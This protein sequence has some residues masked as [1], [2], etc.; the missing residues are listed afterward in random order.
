MDDQKSNSIFNELME[1]YSYYDDLH[2]R[3]LHMKPGE[4]KNLAEFLIKTVADYGI[5]IQP[6]YHMISVA[7]DLNIT[8]IKEFW[9]LFEIIYSNFKIKPEVFNVEPLTYALFCKKIDIKANMFHIPSFLEDDYEITS[10]DEII[11]AY[12]SNTV[13][14]YIIHDDIKS[15]IEYINNSQGFD[16]NSNL[17]EKSLIE[18]CC[19]YGASKCFKFLRSNEIDGN[20]EICL[21]YA[22]DGGKKEIIDECL[23]NA[24]P[25]IDTITEC[26]KLNDADIAFFFMNQYNLQL[27][28][29]SLSEFQNLKLFLYYL[30]ENDN[31]GDCYNESV[32][33]G[34]PSLIEDIINLGARVDDQDEDGLTSLSLAARRNCVEVC[35]MLV[36]LG[37]S[38]E[39]EDKFKQSP[40]AH[41]IEKGCNEVANYLLEIGAN[42]NA[43]NMYGMN[44]LMIAAN[45]N[46][47]EILEKLIQMGSDVNEELSNGDTPL[48]LAAEN[49]CLEA[50]IMLVKHGANI[51]HKNEL[52]RNAILQA[53]HRSLDVTEKLIELGADIESR[54]KFGMTPL[55][56]A[57]K[58]SYYDIAAILI[59][60]GADLEARDAKGNTALMRAREHCNDHIVELLIENGAKQN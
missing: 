41:A 15:L 24:L 17:F 26:V 18:N 40:L 12:E 54:D 19:F 6:V 10:F 30:A 49:D 56:L 39:K 28:L 55:I 42:Y 1:K 8:R 60:A 5:D 47:C 23:Q 59:F 35:K 45:A 48:I 22:I 46:N 32:R 14:K 7:L 20:N 36:K 21:N 31:Y 51:D 53:S 50:V 29:Y 58:N 38:I 43:R 11:N 52:G 27:P 9:E 37:A 25:T 16:L 3:I 13:M 33:F 44:A 4:Q 2:N 57:S 34:I